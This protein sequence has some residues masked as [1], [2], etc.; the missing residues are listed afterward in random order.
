M[1]NPRNNKFLKRSIIVDLS[2]SKVFV[3]VLI[4]VHYPMNLLKV[5]KNPINSSLIMKDI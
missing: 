5:Q 4:A 1:N 3:L 2:F